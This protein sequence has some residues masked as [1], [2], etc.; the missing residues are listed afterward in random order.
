[1]G[2]GLNTYSYVSQNPVRLFDPLG[3]EIYVCSRKGNGFPFVGNHAYAWDSSTNASDSMRGSSGDGLDGS[4][5]KGP[6][7]DSCN[8]VEG[9]KGK[10][11]EIMDFMKKNENNGVWTPGLNDCHNAVK[12]AVENS[13]LEYPGA[14]GGRLGSPEHPP[15][16]SAPKISSA[17]LSAM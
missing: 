11:K 12:D 14:P 7:G 13:G 17:L 15:K 1:M 16:V 10:E 3:L 5:E 2:G 4:G 8:V 9:S 6:S